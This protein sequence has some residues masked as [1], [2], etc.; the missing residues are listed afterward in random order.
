M[1]NY[2]VYAKG[3]GA[4]NNTFDVEVKETGEF[5][6]RLTGE[7]WF[8]GGRLAAG[9]HVLLVD[10]DPQASGPVAYT[11]ILY[12]VPTPPV[13]FAGKSS[14]KSFTVIEFAADFQATGVYKFTLDA[15]SG[16][17]EFF[18][19]DSSFGVIQQQRIITANFTA[20][21]HFFE[22]HPDTSATGA[23]TSWSVNIQLQQALTTPGPAPSP[24][25]C[26]IATAAYGSD[27]S[28]EVQ[29]LRDFRDKQVLP[30]KIGKHFL[31]S[32]SQFYYS[33]SPQAA[34]AI[35][36]NAAFASAARIA[37]RPLLGAL[38]VSVALH[39]QLPASES[40][41]LVSGLVGTFLLGLGYLSIPAYVLLRIVSK[42]RRL[43]PGAF[44]IWLVILGVLII[45]YR[46]E[47]SM[48]LW[49]AT[50][51]LVLLTLV[52]GPA[53]A[54]EAFQRKLEDSSK[55]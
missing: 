9:T 49:P 25:R 55:L 45:G 4:G 23:E 41:L 28:D 29:F 7:L 6:F 50:A 43:A 38:R 2:L 42:G 27:I 51:L 34:E 16:D 12:N 37:L 18:V 52:S 54:S 20:A 35:R 24:S 13:T 17:Y 31:E 36:E 47:H 39:S 1:D 48:L 32:F 40:S 33:F 8:L 21:R 15:I 14:S 10:V 3:G 46:S 22:I 26:L 44:C 30:T 5:W 53:L 11:V 19:D